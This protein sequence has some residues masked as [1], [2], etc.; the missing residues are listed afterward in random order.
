VNQIL[1]D[2]VLNWQIAIREM[3]N[4]KIAIGIVLGIAFGLSVASAAAPDISKLPPAA[5]KKDVTWD[6]DVKPLVEKSCLKCH[7]GEKPKSK[8]RMDTRDTFIKGG[9]SGDPAVVPGKSEKSLVVLYSAGLVEDMEMP[10]TEK[11]DK[12]PAWTK[13]QIALVRA[14]IDQGAK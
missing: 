13:D 11:R 9:E 2:I 7:T 12:Y 3:K 6:K 8:Y 5:A 4:A 14:W 1:N 10:P